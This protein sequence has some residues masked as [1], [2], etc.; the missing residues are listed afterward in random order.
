MKIQALIVED[1]R[2]SRELLK[3]MIVR[4]CPEVEVVGMAESVDT[5][6]RMIHAH[7]PHLIFLDIEMPN[8]T[9]FDLFIGEVSGSA[10]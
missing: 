1:V 10:F 5:A 9:G 8:G 6:V 4:Y 2:K 3:D 7:Q